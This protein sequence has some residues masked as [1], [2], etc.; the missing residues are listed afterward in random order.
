[1]QNEIEW[2]FLHE[3]KAFGESVTGELLLLI[4][5]GGFAY[6]VLKRWGY[7]MHCPVAAIIKEQETA[8]AIADMVGIFSSKLINTN[9]SP[10][11][12]TR[13]LATYHDDVAVILYLPGRY[14][15]DNMETLF[16]ICTCGRIGDCEVSSPFLLVFQKMIPEVYQGRFSF[17]FSAEQKSPQIMDRTCRENFLNVLKK[18]FLEKNQILEHELRMDA[19]NHELIQVKDGIYWKAI[20]TMLEFVFEEGMASENRCRMRRRLEVA[21]K[22][23]HDLSE[24]Y[25][26]IRQMP[27]AFV[28]EFITFIPNMEKMLNK[29]NAT[30]LTGERQKRTVLFDEEYYYIPEELFAQ[31]CEPLKA[32]CSLNQIKEALEKDGILCTQ[33]RGRIYR[34]IKL[35]IRGTDIS[36]RYVWLRRKK[37]DSDCTEMTLEERVNCRKDGK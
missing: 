1:M 35:T 29:A 5:S 6:S 32:V 8:T 12:F 22:K 15:E 33:G 4:E 28:E 21:V 18:Y 36:P 26:Y 3:C 19:M 24:A 11:V 10:K 34:T 37:L 30:A 2:N 7:R 13:E 20:I 14:T 23:G 9:I 16:G 27:A 25:E 17:I 31:I